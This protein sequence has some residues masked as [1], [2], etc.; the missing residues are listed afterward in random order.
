MWP[1]SKK[2]TPTPQVDLDGTDLKVR[3]RETYHSIPNGSGHPMKEDELK[4]TLDT[5]MNKLP[6]A[7]R[8]ALRDN[9]GAGRS[10]VWIFEDAFGMS[11]RKFQ[12]ASGVFAASLK[13]CLGLNAKVFVSSAG[14]TR[15]ITLK[16]K[17]LKKFFE[18]PDADE[19]QKMLHQLGIYR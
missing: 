17:E 10:E 6:D 8:D 13:R 19:D 12:Y 2:I 16:T 4:R 14:A 18:A 1:F 7:F 9:D 5:W 15:S 11:T 3:L